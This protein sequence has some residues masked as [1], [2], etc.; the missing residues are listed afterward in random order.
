MF[1][2]LPVTVVLFLYKLRHAPTAGTNQRFNYIMAWLALPLYAVHQ[3]EEHGYDLYGRRYHFIDYFNEVKPLGVELTPRMITII[4]LV[5]VHL[6]FGFMAVLFEQ[7]GNPIFGVLSSSLSFVNGFGMHLVPALTKHTY[8]PG[9]AQSVLMAPLSGWVVYKYCFDY[10]SSSTSSQSS[11]S[12][13][14]SIKAL[15]ICLVFGGPWGHGLCLLLPLRLFHLG[16]LN[17]WGFTL[18]AAVF[19]A[20]YAL[21]A[22]RILPPSPK[23]G[24]MSD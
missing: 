12:T 13:S 14:T 2:T 17:E 19:L 11:S 7:T 4:N 10:C 5:H 18:W 8:N 6:S 21:L 9:A 24:S 15:I 23:K 22:S 3:F 20:S 1:V 16:Y